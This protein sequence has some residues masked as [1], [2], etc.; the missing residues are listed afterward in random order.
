MKLHHVYL[1]QAAACAAL[2][3]RRR[4]LARRLAALRRCS[5]QAFAQQF[6]ACVAA[7]ET[8]FREE[9]TLLDRLDAP[10]LH[11]RL[12]DHALILCA[13]HRTAFRVEAGDLGR[14]REVAAALEAILAPPLPDFLRAQRV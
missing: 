4:R 9:E 14:G 6:P 7:V 11:P 8:A 13:L 12:A 5:D 10:C 1:P 3:H 2:R